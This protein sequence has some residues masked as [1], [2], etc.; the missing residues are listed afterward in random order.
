MAMFINGLN[1]LNSNAMPLVVLDGVVYDMLYD[2]RMLHN[3]Y[4]N[5]LLQAINVDDI[6]SVNVLKNGTAIYGAKAANGVIEIKT[7]RCHSM[8]TR[9]DVNINTGFEVALKVF[10][11]PSFSSK[12]FLA[13]SKSASNP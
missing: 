7:K 5:N 8:A 9:I 3:G 12:Y 11:A 10:P 6:E 13:F 4:F 2:T 1:S